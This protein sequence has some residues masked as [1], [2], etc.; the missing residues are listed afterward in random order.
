MSITM[1]TLS[2]AGE[3]KAK[4]TICMPMVRASF[5]WELGS[6][7]SCHS[8]LLSL[9]GAPRGIRFEYQTLSSCMF[10]R[11]RWNVAWKQTL[12]ALGM[13]LLA[14]TAYTSSDIFWGWAVMWGGSKHPLK[15]LNLP[16]QHSSSICL[17]CSKPPHCCPRNSAHNCGRSLLAVQ[18][19]NWESNRNR[20][21]RQEKVH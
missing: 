5:R 18:R 15:L 7:S 4:V 13:D 1:F 6:F 10:E 20:W 21:A 9:K 14:V 12:S 2:I 17:V 16:C 11:Q 8:Q 3:I 19:A